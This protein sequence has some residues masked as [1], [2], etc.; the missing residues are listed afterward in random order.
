MTAWRQAGHRLDGI[1]MR[2][3]R[4]ACCASRCAAPACALRAGCLAA[5]GQRDP[6]PPSRRGR[7][8]SGDPG[9][10]TFFQNDAP[11]IYG[12]SNLRRRFSK[13]LLL[14]G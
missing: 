7:R 11:L 2:V 9:G 4:C 5:P 3:A 13:R 8:D 1:A 12:A 10:G 6:P 14:K